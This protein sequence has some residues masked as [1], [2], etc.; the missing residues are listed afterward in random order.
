MREFTPPVGRIAGTRTRRRVDA[1]LLA[2]LTALASLALV[3]P[4]L[5]APAR[6]D[7]NA[8]IKVTDL[9]LTK[10]DRSGA[11]LEGPLKVKDIA[12]LSFTWDAT[13]AN[14]KAGDTFTI[15]LGEYFNNLVQPQTASM[16]V[17]YNGQITEVGTCTLDKTMV[18]CTFN[19]KIDQY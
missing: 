2:L 8:G 7:V 15:G 13:G 9:T 14:P 5:S 11:D 4:G 17:T 10:S 12:K 19:G 3:L 6:A 1:V 16:A 18:T